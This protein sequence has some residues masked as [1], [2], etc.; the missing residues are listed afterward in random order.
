MKIINSLLIIILSAALVT[1]V[2][3]SAVELIGKIVGSSC[4]HQGHFCPLEN[5]EEHIAMEPDFVIVGEDGSYHHLH[6]L[7]RD[8]KVRN[9][10]QTVTVVGSPDKS[11]SGIYVTHLKTGKKN[12]WSW[13]QQTKEGRPYFGLGLK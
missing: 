2:S 10:G 4:A 8:T 3:V 7:P 12:I 9:V 11:G 6:N 13:E 1:P 5:L